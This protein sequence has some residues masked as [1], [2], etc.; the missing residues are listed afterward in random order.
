METKATLETLL[1]SLIAAA[2]GFIGWQTYVAKGS[3]K[4]VEPESSR[5]ICFAPEGDCEA[6]IVREIG[7]AQHQILM[8]AYTYT[9]GTDIPAALVRAVQRG[10]DVQIIADKETPCGNY[11]AI[12]VMMAANIPVAIDDQPPIAHEKAL[13]IDGA[14][15]VE[16]SYNFTRQA[17]RNSESLNV[18]RSIDIAAAYTRHWKARAAAA[19][20]LTGAVPSHWCEHRRAAPGH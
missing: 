7:S 8:H 5:E 3:A 11:S 20:H 19:V 15:V 12:P 13:I 2:I 18:V 17:A 10:V 9:I 16:G 4:L 1:L 14:T 6:V